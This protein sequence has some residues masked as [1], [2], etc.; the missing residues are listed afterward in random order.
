MMFMK[1][2]M[3]KYEWRMKSFAR[4]IDPDAVVAE[5]ERIENVYGSL[6]AENVLRASESEDALLHKLFEW[7]DSKAA[8]QYRMQQA[9]NIINNVEIRIIH[10]GEPR[11]ISVYEVVNVGEQRVYKHIDQMSESEVEQVRR[12]T[13]RNLNTLREKLSVYKEFR[14]VLRH[15]D[16][17]IGSL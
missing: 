3:N 16:A 8:E 17:A 11:Q 1:D 9:R 2:K 10:D 13:L 4:G 12:A 14:K 15:I 7:D 6:T 5:L